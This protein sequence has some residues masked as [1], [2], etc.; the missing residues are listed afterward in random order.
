MQVLTEREVLVLV[1]PELGGSEEGITE[2][3]LDLVRK[4]H[5]ALTRGGGSRLCHVRTPRAERRA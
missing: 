4:Q 5:S 2:P 1:V 3:A